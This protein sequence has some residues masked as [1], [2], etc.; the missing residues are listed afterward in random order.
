MNIH[1]PYTRRQALGGIGALS[2]AGLLAAACGNSNVE[3]NSSGRTIELISINFPPYLTAIDSQVGSAYT[4]RTGITVKVV[5]TGANNY[6]TVDTRVKADLAA[7]HT[8]DMALIAMSA[9]GNYISAN[10]AIALDPLI[11]TGH[12]DTGQLYPS[13]L[14]TASAN[15]HIYAIP[16]AA[17]TMIM[18]YNADAFTKA[19]LDPDKPPKTFSELREHAKAL[20]ASKA[21]KYG[22]TYGNDH[23]AN[24][25]FENFLFSNGGT[26]LSDDGKTPLF[27]Q[28]PGV[29]VLQFWADLFADG[30]GQTM[31][32]TEEAA[33]FGRGDL[34]IMLNSSSNIQSM[35]ASTKFDLR[36]ATL[37]VP[38]GGSL[39]CAAGGGA[40][41]VMAKDEP[42]QKTA[43]DVI[44]QL[45]SPTAITTL[46]KGSGSSPVNKIAATESNY[47]ADFLAKNP[48]Y[49]PATTQMN[50]LVR[51][52]AWPGQKSAEITSN[53]DQQMV[54]ALRGSKSP[55]AALNDAAKQT[56]SM[57]G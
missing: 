2:L 26:M 22:V 46:V 29:D 25:G 50:S 42:S 3:S 1:A 51:W 5:N 14:G 48:L 9:I 40:F 15:G 13:L 33:A 10:R 19:G 12:L 57:L 21:A 37:P 38:D 4:A 34:A 23:G 45:I 6:A 36:T 27:N 28:Q 52:F 56:R 54:L 47:L 31:T 8:P 24:W 11:A 7:G 20:V 30:Y 17:S 32:S 53:L 35:A 41:I 18:F 44:S 43:L 55:A 39:K 49:T 16:Y